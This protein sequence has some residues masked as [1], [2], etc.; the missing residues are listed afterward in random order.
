MATTNYA[1]T[2]GGYYE[3]QRRGI[4][5]KYTT[6]AASN[7]YGR[8]LSQ[9]RGQ[10]GLSDMTD[11]FNRN[12]TPYR[13]TFAQRGLA[14]GD[15]SS[16]IQRGAMQRYV[17]DYYQNYGRAQQD[18]TQNLQQYDLSQSQ[19][20]SWRQNE[21]ANL[22]LQQAQEIASAAQNLEALRAYLGGI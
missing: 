19:L 20:D 17:G 7:A 13:S 22:Q 5:N 9:Q 15:V 2:N 8:F 4:E 6:D 3:S 10:R 16:G 18:L 11:Q 14:G 1:G 21:L 12:Y